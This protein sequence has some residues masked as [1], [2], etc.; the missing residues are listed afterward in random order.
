MLLYRCVNATTIGGEKMFDQKRF[1]A[2]VSLTGTTLYELCNRIGMNASTLYR[3][4]NGI[5]DFTRK[6][7]QEIKNALNWDASTV[8][9][10]FFAPDV[11]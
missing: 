6:E 2:E 11:A 5:S 4:M 9:Q 3:K 7:I 10:I 1:K 8:D